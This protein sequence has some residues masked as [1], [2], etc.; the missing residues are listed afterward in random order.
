MPL[1]LQPTLLPP[2]PSPVLW[3][4]LLVP[5]L[6]LL[7]LALPMLPKPLLTLLPKP[8]KLL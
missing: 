4:L 7:P 8:P 5:L 3:K 6:T 2:Q 1:L